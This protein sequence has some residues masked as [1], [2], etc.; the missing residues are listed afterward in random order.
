M[1]KF[2]YHGRMFDEEQVL[3]NLADA[4]Q[5]IKELKDKIDLLEDEK[6]QLTDY[7]E[8]ALGQMNDE[9]ARLNGQLDI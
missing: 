6:R 3:G 1:A 5:L 4:E 2:Y 7:Y 8:N 9:I